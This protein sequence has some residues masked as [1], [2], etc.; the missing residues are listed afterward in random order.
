M[1]MRFLRFSAILFLVI[2]LFSNSTFASGF[3]N[4]V[5]GTKARGMGGAFRAVADDW[6]ASYFNPAGLAFILDNQLGADL[7]LLHNRHV[8]TP[9]YRWPGG[10]NFEQ[11]GIYNNTPINNFHEIHSRPSGGVVV[12]LPVWGETVFGFSAYQPF[13]YNITW[14]LYKHSPAY[15]NSQNLPGDE[16]RNDLDVVAFQVSAAH[17]YTVN[18]RQLA[19]GLG[20]QLLRA[21]ILFNDVL[22]RDNPFRDDPVDKI[23]QVSHNDGSGWGIGFRA[24]ALLKVNDKLNLALTA[25]LPFDINVSGNA[26]M[27]THM[28]KTDFDPNLIEFNPGQPHHLFRSGAKVLDSANFDSQL[29]LPVSIGTGLSYLVTEKLRLAVDAELTFWSHYEGIDFEF[30]NHR[31]IPPAGD[32]SQATKEFLT[33]NVTNPVSWDNTLKGLIGLDYQ[34]SQVITLLGGLSFDQSPARDAKQITPQFV[35]TG[36]RVGISGGVTFHIQQWDL[37]VVS[38]YV[39]QPDLTVESISDFDGDG[40]PDSFAGDYQ[41]DTYETVLSFNYRF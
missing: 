27:E 10:S 19:L 38:S 13:D 17:E 9:N 35:D 22:F 23:T 33:A 41:A 28:P 40:S 24:G 4:T 18:G 2:G 32:T 30:S 34:Y 14:N 29:D 21:D 26:T 11:Q 3:E 25:N 5:I 8:L 15:N 16:Y 31:G 1:G 12:R 37:S 36:T 39:Q 20:I 6:T 7:S